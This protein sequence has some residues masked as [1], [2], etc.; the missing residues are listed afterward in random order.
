MK[1]S[2]CGQCNRK[3]LL[4]CFSLMH[5]TGFAS[6]TDEN[7]SA[8]EQEVE[9]DS[10]F[11]YVSDK[12][13]ID[14]SRFASSASVLPGIYRTAVYV[15]NT[16]S[17]KD[18]IHFISRQDGSV[19][20]CFNASLLK[21]IP[22]AEAKLPEDF[23]HGIR[24]S[25]P[26]SCIDLREK[27]PQAEVLYD[28][29]EQR[30]DISV[31]QILLV[32]KAR[33]AVD[34]EEWDS[35]IAAM[36]LGYNITGYRSESQ[37]NVW[38]SAY[39]TLNA[40][41]NLGPWYFRH[42][43]NGN[44]QE[45]K[46][47]SYNAV[48]TWLQRDLPVIQGRI[49]AGQTS[50]PGLIFDT[51][52]FSGVQIASDDRML[53]YSLRGYA[54]EIR[55][56]ARTSARVTVRQNNQ[57]IYDTTVP[58]GEFLIND[59]YPAGYGSDLYVTVREADGS[60]QNFQVPYSSIAQLLRPGNHRYSFTAGKIRSSN[61]HDHP[62]FWE[63]TWQYGFSNILTGWSGLQLSERYS[64][65]QFGAAL[66]TS[67]GAFALDITHAR[68]SEKQW[69]NLQKSSGE[70]YKF[71][72]SK[73]VDATSSNLTLSAWQFS[74]QG[75][76]DLLTT[77]Q[78]RQ[79]LKSGTS[80][81]ASWRT[82]QRLTLTLDQSL[83]TGF[84]HLTFSGSIQNYWNQPHDTR[85]FQFGYSNR[86]KSL[87][88]G[89]TA[90]RTY[91]SDGDAENNYLLNFT[92][93]LAK[94]ASHT[95]S[96]LRVDLS[97]DGDGRY[98][99][100]ATLTGTLGD[101]NPFSYGISAT[102]EN[103]NGTSGSVTGSY[104]SRLTAMSGSWSQGSGYKSGSFS[105][106]GTMLAHAGGVTL[107]PYNSDTFALIEARG[108]EGARVSTYPGVYVDHAGF[109]AVPY[110]NPYQLN[111]VTIDPV[112]AS[113]SIE[114][115]NT[116]QRVVPWSGAVV[117]VK[118][119]TRY[120]NPLLINALYNGE[121]VRFGAE[122]IDEEGNSLGSVG[123]AGQ[124]FVRVNTMQGQ[125]TVKWAEGADGRCTVDYQLQRVKKEKHPRLQR[126][127]TVC[128]GASSDALPV[129]NPRE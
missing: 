60:E 24:E 50:T 27:L 86:F 65:V 41:L 126:F 19:Y 15:N 76:Q 6:E 85:Q 22:F 122:V 128:A 123:Q 116:T 58:P 84:G 43:G 67:A 3:A 97:R 98:A 90:N 55:G 100:Q 53:P 72:Y 16:A 80:T 95:S 103:G 13:A 17:G 49:L 47:F 48:N 36:P 68:D 105:L 46:E 7:I 66:G 75:Y 42:N 119:N 125:L 4:L 113:S 52:P 18:D 106:S 11:L 61:L 40:G 79:S 21:K 102:S 63:A 94:S 71:S 44:W 91:S 20:A 81:S 88:W 78:N 93:P 51:L 115:D 38:Q 57:L 104:H 108:A 32:K 99:R 34:R 73:T 117:A 29:N 87:T 83:P 89:I 45:H 70:S 37:G 96:Q 111:E 14:L 62:P 110:L 56:I 9:F 23:Y 1:V 25:D 31:P 69:N 28:S 10:S 82:R 39:G 101:A 5:I 35:G 30:L 114:L 64:A 92:L 26:E 124:I 129:N 54:P 33:G 127:N 8:Q 74:S 59:I 120:G 109:A 112:G 77:L 118:Y 12:N 121:P 2:F 107:T